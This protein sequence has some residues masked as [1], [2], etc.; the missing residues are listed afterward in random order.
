MSRDTNIGVFK[1]SDVLIDSF[2]NSICVS[3]VY[4][5]SIKSDKQFTEKGI[6][7]E[8]FSIGVR[9]R[10]KFISCFPLDI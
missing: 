9:K 1:A 4:L 8:E 2:K 6:I 3:L 5:H 7:F 10:C